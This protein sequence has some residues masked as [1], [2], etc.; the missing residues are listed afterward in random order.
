METNL[1]SNIHI[2]NPFLPPKKPKKM[3][4]QKFKHSYYNHSHN[5]S[6][7]EFMLHSVR[8]V[9]CLQAVVVVILTAMLGIVLLFGNATAQ[10]CLQHTVNAVPSIVLVHQLVCRIS[11]VAVELH[12]QDA[13]RSSQQH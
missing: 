4:L 3:F 9:F 10:H 2:I 7:E 11:S 8:I 13:Q 6:K 5:F 12:L 1:E